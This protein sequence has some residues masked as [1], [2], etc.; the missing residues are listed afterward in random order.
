M[1][2][3]ISV[4]FIICF[5]GIFA[6]SVAFAQNPTANAG[7]DL[8][9]NS[10]QSGVLLGSGYDSTGYSL[11]YHWSCNGGS[12]SNS[13]I[14][15]PTYTA[16]YVHQYNNQ[17]TYTCALTVSNNYG[18]S[19]SDSA[20]IFVNYNN[21]SNLQ[22][23]T[24]SATNVSNYQA[25]L[26][27]YVTSPSYGNTTRTWFQWGTTINYGNETTHQIAGS[28]GSFS[29]NIANLSSGTTYHFRAAAQLNNGNVVYGQDRTFYT[30]GSGNYYG[31]GNLIVNKKVINLTS[32]NL[33][34]QP[35]VNA[36]PSDILSFVITIQADQASAH[37]VFVRDSLPQN[38]IYRGNLTINTNINYLGDP[39]SGINVGTL[40]AG[41]IYVIA[42]QVQVV[43]PQNLSYGTTV[44]N[45]SATVTSSDAGSKTASAQVLV[46]NSIVSG[47]T[48]LPT[49]TTN[50]PIT[51]S[52]LL[53]LFLIVLASWLYFSGRANKFAD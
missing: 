14:A 27:G 53:P 38:L 45:N 8:N 41:Q 4:I 33:N 6:G 31:A 25:T 2:F 43:S 5:A 52:F 22:V 13:S 3:K 23:Q 15:Q 47:A 48:Y 12:L 20:T 1:S 39:L 28:S 50:N 32:G 40:T 21:T 24:N 26:N 10:G 30:S 42:Y 49:G 36:K 34:W 51:D 46:S 19:S 9:L 44:L 29:Q 16:P 37:N 18:Y 7:P 35:S 11:N 17:A